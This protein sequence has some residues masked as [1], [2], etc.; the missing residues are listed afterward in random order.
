MFSFNRNFFKK[1]IIFMHENCPG[2][3]YKL[4]CQILSASYV[5]KL[6]R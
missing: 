1:K 6:L 3:Y 2:D 5:I 4:Q